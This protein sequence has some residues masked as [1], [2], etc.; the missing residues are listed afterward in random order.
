M[1]PI[2]SPLLARFLGSLGKVQHHLHTVIVGLSGVEKK[3]AIKPGDLDINWRA[4]DP[5][6]S[7]REAR[8]FILRSTLIF[9]AEELNEYAKGVLNY[10][11]LAGGKADIPQ[12]RADRVRS[13]ANPYQIDPTYLAVAPVIVSQWRNRIVHRDS[14]SEI[15]KAEERLLLENKQSIHDR[16]KHIDV[17]RL[18]HDFRSDNPTLKETT[19]LLAMSINF[20]TKVDSTLPYPASAADVRRWL[21]VDNHWEKILELER[22]SARGGHTDPRSR[23]KNYLITK[24][25][26]LADAYYRLGASDE[27]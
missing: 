22:A 10:R 17:A 14:N 9:L 19:V 8:H 1:P 13:L 3:T 21:I 18:L 15:H 26:R 24:S 20:V 27:I 16:Y 7:A 23:G 2:E 12:K 6:G 4:D 25:P 5:V 11:T